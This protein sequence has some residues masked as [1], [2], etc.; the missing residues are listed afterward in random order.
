M[1]ENNAGPTGAA[2]GRIRIY[3]AAGDK[4]QET[5]RAKFGR[6]KMDRQYRSGQPA[7]WQWE[8]A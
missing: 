4:R 3:L 5:L 2:Q 1:S 8:K 7:R 6:D